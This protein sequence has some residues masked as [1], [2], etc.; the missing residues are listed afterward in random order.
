MFWEFLWAVFWM[1]L[2]AYL[3]AAFAEWNRYYKEPLKERAYRS[4]LWP[5]W[6]AVD[7]LS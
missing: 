3:L 5:L 1:A 2:G 6:S 4:L 7:I